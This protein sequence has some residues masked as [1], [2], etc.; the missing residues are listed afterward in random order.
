MEAS[1]PAAATDQGISAAMMTALSS[2]PSASLEFSGSTSSQSCYVSI[3]VRVWLQ[4]SIAE[5]TDVPSI[6]A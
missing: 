5:S 1:G 4:A 2:S 6:A 3:T